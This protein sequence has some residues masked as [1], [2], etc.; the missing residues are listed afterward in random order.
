MLTKM[1]VVAVCALAALSCSTDRSTSEPLSQVAQAWQPQPPTAFPTTLCMA[2]AYSLKQTVIGAKTHVSGPIGSAGDVRV[3]ASA[4]VGSVEASG[5]I[6]LGSGASVTGG[7]EA[8]GT[9]TKQAN[10]RISGTTSTGHAV[11]ALTILSPAVVA[12]TQGVTV[13]GHQHLSLPPG[14]YGEVRA[15]PQSELT[16]TTGIYGLKSFILESSD[17]HLV[18]DVRLGPIVVNVLDDMSFGD[19]LVTNVLDNA[20]SGFVQFYSV[21]TTDVRIGNAAD[22]FGVIIAPNAVVHLSP[23]A[24]VKGAVYGQQ[25]VLDQ[26]SELV[27]TGCPEAEDLGSPTCAVTNDSKQATLSYSATCDGHT[28]PHPALTVQ[29]QFTTGVPTGEVDLV[30]TLRLGGAPLLTISSKSEG[31]TTT[32][33]VDYAPPIKGITRATFV[34][35]GSTMSGNVDGR[36][37][38]PVPLSPSALDPL[39][40]PAMR[41]A[42][43]RPP[44]NVST[45]KTIESGLAIVLAQAQIGGRQKCDP[46][47]PSCDSCEDNCNTEGYV[48]DGGALLCLI[49]GPFAGECAAAASAVCAVKYEACGMN[50]EAPGNA[51]C[52]VPCSGGA[53]CNFGDQCLPQGLG[54]CTLPEIICGSQC[55]PTGIVQCDKAGG[56]CPQ[57]D[58]PCGPTCCAPGEQCSDSAEGICCAPTQTPC[59][60]NC[61]AP[62]ELCADSVHGVCCPA[63]IATCGGGCCG[64]QIEL[65]QQPGNVCCQ[66]PLCNG[67]CCGNAA[68]VNGQCCFGPTTS[69]GE[70]CGFGTT[71]CSGQCC[72]GSCTTGGICCPFGETACGSECCLEFSACFDSTT[73]TC[74]PP[75]PI[76][77]EPTTITLPGGGLT[78]VCVPITMPR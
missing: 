64:T 50:C 26:D 6:V 41:F 20:D 19:R 46:S 66:T 33:V 2:S 29:A 18:L 74:T 75:C 17:V 43:G 30:E 5:N 24:F 3:G 54:C 45:P 49:A 14:L 27:G 44:P 52:Q 71:I 53:C 77:E 10:V 9:L 36:A 15:H 57:A 35:D 60:T 61:C 7:V 39:S 40:L 51:C 38:I 32:T 23:D 65:C 69:T 42:D 58:T 11:P 4:Q 31:Q 25:V 8:Q 73:S 34:Y 47:N 22:I 63:G 13:D 76:G 68:C 56:C 55:C 67:Q 21:G 37:L 28:C 59:G 72:A 1:R 70:C 12:G 62:G 78:I 16:L 48:C